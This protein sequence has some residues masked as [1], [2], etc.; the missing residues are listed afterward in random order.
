MPGRSGANF[1]RVGV[2]PLGQ[3]QL[4]E[5][6]LGDMQSAGQVRYCDSTGW[7]RL[8]PVCSLAVPYL[9]LCLCTLPTNA[10]SPPPMQAAGAVGLDTA[11]KDAAVQKVEA[12]LGDAAGLKATLNAQL[13]KAAGGAG[14]GAGAGAAADAP[15]AAT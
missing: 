12:A 8:R 10:T 6:K 2:Y 13:D 11:T 4:A 14:A 1:P 7:T 5:A 3:L 9:P 15:A